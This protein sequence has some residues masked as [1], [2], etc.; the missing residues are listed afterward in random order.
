[1]APWS[2]LEVLKLDTLLFCLR[3]KAK[4]RVENSIAVVGV[5]KALLIGNSHSIPINS[6][7]WKEN[8]FSTMAWKC[9]QAS[10]LVIQKQNTV[11][12]KKFLGFSGTFLV[13]C[14]FGNDK[15][16]FEKIYA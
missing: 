14:N 4:S 15:T 6:Y 13:F 5:T 7:S 2:G 10:C 8:I 1:M 3:R 9:L 16:I 11:K 12:N